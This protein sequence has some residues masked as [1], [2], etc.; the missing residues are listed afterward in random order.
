MEGA[1][2]R[3]AVVN[4]CPSPGRLGGGE[5]LGEGAAGGEASPV[6]ALGSLS[7]TD[8]VLGVRTFS[9]VASTGSKRDGE[10]VGVSVLP[11]PMD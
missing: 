9:K 3:H 5:Q 8:K 2:H 6:V 11:F 10:L 4:H 1:C 7:N